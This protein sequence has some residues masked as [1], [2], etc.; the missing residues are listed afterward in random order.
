M[1]HVTYSMNLYWMN[2]YWL[3]AVWA[4][5]REPASFVGE[6][7]CPHLEETTCPE[8]YA[9]SCWARASFRT[10]LETRE[11]ESQPCKHHYNYKLIQHFSNDCWLALKLLPVSHLEVLVSIGELLTK[12]SNNK[13][14]FWSL[15]PSMFYIQQ[16][17]PWQFNNL[18]WNIKLEYH[19]PTQPNFFN[20]PDQQL[21]QLVRMAI[22]S[23]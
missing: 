4:S 17:S 20:I 6:A 2:F 12:I 22:W 15:D 14:C 21:F 18:K 8:T 10:S 19:L 16:R 9:S 23:D 5:Y 11:R 7:T 13:H 3:N 1:H